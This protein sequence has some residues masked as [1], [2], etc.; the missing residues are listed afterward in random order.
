MKIVSSSLLININ[1]FGH[2]LYIVSKFTLQNSGTIGAMY[3]CACTVANQILGL[4]DIN[5]KFY[6][7]DITLIKLIKL[8]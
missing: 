1:F 7:A 5:L 8:I 6:T 2:D 3:N 4:P